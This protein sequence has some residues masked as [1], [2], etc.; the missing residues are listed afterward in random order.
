MSAEIESPANESTFAQDVLAP[1]PPPGGPSRQVDGGAEGSSTSPTN[2]YATIAQLTAELNRAN[3]AL[4][5][6][7][8]ALRSLKQ[9]FAWK[10]TAPM[11]IL[12]K[13]YRRN[14]R[15]LDM[16]R[17][18][19]GQSLR[20]NGELGPFNWTIA[21]NDPYF[22]LLPVDSNRF[23][24]NCWAVLD[25]SMKVSRPT[26]LRVT[27]ST[28][29]GFRQG[30]AVH[31]PIEQDARIKIPLFLPVGFDR[32]RVEPNLS[33][34]Q[35]DLRDI[36]LRY[37]TKRPTAFVDALPQDKVL[38]PS[39]PPLKSKPLGV[40]L[41]PINQL[42]PIDV[43]GHSWQSI[44]GDPFFVV[45][46][47]PDLSRGW[48]RISFEIEISSR[49]GLAKFYFD[50]G[51]GFSETTV[52][53]LPYV[54]SEPTSRIVKIAGPV[55]ALRFDPLE[56]A[57]KFE[58]MQLD[59]TAISAEEAFDSIR[60]TL[61]I[62][63]QKLAEGPIGA[64]GLANTQTPEEL[65]QRYESLF[66]ID[67]AFLG[68][69]DWIELN[70]KPSEPTD[71]ALEEFYATQPE[72]PLISI[73]VPTYETDYWA[74]RECIESVLNQ[75]MPNWELCIAD[76]A[77]RQP[78]VRELIEFY[79][80]GDSRVKTVFRSE[81]GHISECSN[82]ALALC[83]GAFVA[84]LDHD[85]LLHRHAI[86]YVTKEILSHPNVQV[87]YSDEDKVDQ[88]GTR[89]EP[90]FKSTWNPELFF[91][92]NYVSHLGVYRKS[93]LDAIGGFRSGVEG[94]QDYD[95]MLRTLRI[96]SDD[97]I[98]HIPKVLYHWRTLAG[99]TAAS[100]DGKT[101]TTDAGRKAL[102]DF[103]ESQTSAERFPVPT[104]I[105]AGVYP[106][107]YRLTYPTPTHNP[108]VSIIIP[109]K[110]AAGLTRV[111]VDSILSKTTYDNYEILIVDN[112]STEAAT[113]EFFEAV[114]KADERVRVLKY[115]APFNYSAI[116]NF[117]VEHANGEYIA[118]VNNDIE[119]ISP[120]WLSEMLG[121]AS[122]PAVGCV[123]AKLYYANDTVQHAGV[124]C[125]LGGV[126][127]HSHK[128][129]DRNHP[130]YFYR[131][132]LPQAV[133]AVTAACLLVRKAI[134]LEVGGLDATNLTIAFNDVDFC[135]KVKAAGYRNV[136]T[137]YA[138]LYHHE[139]VSRGQEDSPQKLARFNSE[140]NFMKQK[141][142]QSLQ[143][144]PYYNP[145]LTR[146]RE[147]FTI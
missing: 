121:H 29:G 14:L 97:S 37:K 80:E 28:Q 75:S 6:S 15:N 100:A 2:D 146:A 5:D 45:R 1:T 123:G 94:S 112:G 10:I 56:R 118:L 132:V 8:S 57:G 48:A 22:L 32:L 135:L 23:R 61:L 4:F 120:D 63:D 145:N 84:L 34:G 35:M 76:D 40:S 91:A 137:P 131:L 128:H 72:L 47:L 87:I 136:F 111:C 16:V 119:V 86:Y 102:T 107:T 81:N 134:Y 127:G 11:R 24:E 108:L 53:S 138:E 39:M 85:D 73:I 52:V 67:Q 125:G 95:L 96:V 19:P 117:A 18:V 27:I 59:V 17:A 133:S 70:E 46:G 144:D 78:H 105:S 51:H 58:I 88:A 33:D 83:N 124:I 147:D 116:N 41:D 20:Y 77:S 99:S 42:D 38:P 12:L 31:F 109:T 142:Q 140:I 21:G 141:W 9:S 44:G 68:Y 26:N 114:Q 122:Q 7:R 89:S 54:S 66:E 82:S 113:F 74:L 90:H 143:D 30:D 36:V 3:A 139:S 49:S 43:S 50:Y 55:K 115:D 79:A 126:A 130:G 71:R 129:F 92:Q 25:V 62:E 101:Y 103:F 13:F 69:H 65:R 104:Q 98:R 110:D 64:E 93:V 106:N 60:A